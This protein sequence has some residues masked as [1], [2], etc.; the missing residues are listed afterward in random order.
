MKGILFVNG[1]YTSENER[2]RNERLI[3]E[4]SKRNVDVSVY[5]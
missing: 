1:Y 2:Y 3:E 4:F 5:K